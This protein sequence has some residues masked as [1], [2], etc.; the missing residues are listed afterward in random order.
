MGCNK[1]NEWRPTL[2]RCQNSSNRDSYIAMLL[3]SG[4]I[5]EMNQDFGQA[6]FIF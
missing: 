6:Q 3:E 2:V 1:A 4:V 5:D